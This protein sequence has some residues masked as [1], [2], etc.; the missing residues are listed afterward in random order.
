MSILEPVYMQNWQINLSGVGKLTYM[1]NLLLL[2]V[3]MCMCIV[4]SGCIMQ[5]PFIGYHTFNNY[6]D[7]YSLQYPSDW[8]IDSSNTTVYITNGGA[9]VNV[10]SEP[11]VPNTTLNE[12][13]QSQIP[14]PNKIYNGGWLVVGLEQTDITVKGFP[15][16]KVTYNMVTHDG[17]RTTKNEFVYFIR[18]DRIYTVSYIAN[19]PEFYNFH[20]AAQKIIDSLTFNS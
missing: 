17:S 11:I 2:S 4:S 16:K 8:K 6:L 18:G 20:S 9:K 3:M 5:N 1:K 10:Q 12:Y 7:N 14:D 15:A 19:S 13:V